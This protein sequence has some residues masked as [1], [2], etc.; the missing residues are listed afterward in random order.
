MIVQT[1]ACGPYFDPAGLVA[2]FI[3][4]LLIKPLSYYAYVRAFRYRVCRAIPMT[5]RQAI[6]LAVLRGGL[7]LIMVGGGAWV[8]GAYWVGAVGFAMILDTIIKLT[9]HRGR[10]TDDLHLGGSDY[11][12]KGIGKPAD[13]KSRRYNCLAE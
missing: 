13:T 5:T 11:F 4:F 3:L 9:L 7:G 10:S 6:R 2:S 12:A 8:I 1:L